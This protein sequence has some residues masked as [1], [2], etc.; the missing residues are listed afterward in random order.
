MDALTAKI[1][2]LV[3]VSTSDLSQTSISIALTQIYHFVENGGV[4]HIGSD[5]M[6]EC[7]NQGPTD[8]LL[9]SPSWFVSLMLRD[10]SWPNILILKN[11]IEK[12]P[13]DDDEKE[14]LILELIATLLTFI[15]RDSTSIR[16]YDT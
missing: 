8:C 12:I 14:S 2:V 13:V 4:I 7:Q 15:K 3:D 16:M 6:L 11:L 1:K 5:K 10:L 9:I